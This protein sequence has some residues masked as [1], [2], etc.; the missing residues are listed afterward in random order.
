M[1]SEKF[2][3]L[4]EARHREGEIK[5]W[6]RKKKLKLINNNDIPQYKALILQKLLY[7]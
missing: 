5:T 7:N 3:V 6:N 4:K 2:K 1:Y